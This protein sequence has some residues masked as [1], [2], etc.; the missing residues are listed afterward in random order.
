MTW[1]TILKGLKYYPIRE[2]Q[3]CTPSKW[4]VFFCRHLSFSSLGRGSWQRQAVLPMEE[5]RMHPVRL[6]VSSRRASWFGDCCRSKSETLPISTYVISFLALLC[7]FL[8]HANCGCVVCS[9]FAIPYY[10]TTHI[11]LQL[12]I[13]SQQRWHMLQSRRRHVSIFCFWIVYFV[14]VCLYASVIQVSDAMLVFWCRC[15][16]VK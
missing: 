7:I 4:C 2:T 8:S 5:E 1:I 16:S 14:D 11:T 9:F 10:F 12:R 13:R 6:S 15:V 3:R